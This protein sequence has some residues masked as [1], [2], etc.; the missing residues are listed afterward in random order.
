MKFADAL[1]TVK[2][3]APTINV[4]IAIGDH[5]L[6]LVCKRLPGTVWAEIISRSPATTEHHMLTGY[7]TEKAARLATTEHATLI[8]SEGEPVTDVDWPTLFDTISGVELR[9]LAAAWWGL[10]EQDPSK[11][12]EQLKKALKTGSIPATSSR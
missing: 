11:R 9:A 6:H 8:D 4:P 1:K 10:N 3:D 7:N 2:K 5:L 12:V